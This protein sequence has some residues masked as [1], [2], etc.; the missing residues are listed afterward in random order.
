MGRVPGELVRF[1]RRGSSILL[2]KGGPGTGKTILSLELLRRFSK[3]STGIYLGTRVSA[4]RMLI[5]HP[6]LKGF[7][8]PQH[9]L[10]TEAPPA[11]RISISDTRFRESPMENLFEV[12]MEAENPFVVIDSWEVVAKRVGEREGN[13]A[14]EVLETLVA[15]K[16]T[17]LVFVSETTGETP[18]DFQADGMVALSLEEVEGRTLR[19]LDLRKLRGIRIGQRKQLFSLDRGRFH[20][21]P[22]FNSKGFG[23]E[24]G[25]K[26]IPDSKTHFSTGCV[27]LDR[28]LGGGYPRGGTVL[29]EVHPH[30]PRIVSGIFSVSVIANFFSQGRGFMGIPS[31][32]W[33]LGEITDLGRHLFGEQAFELPIRILTTA[34][35]SEQTPYIVQLTGEDMESDF[36]VW[37]KTQDALL[38]ETGQPVLSITH[39]RKQVDR[40]GEDAYVKALGLSVDSL[41]RSGGIEIRISTAGIENVTRKAAE[42][43]DTYLSIETRFGCVYLYGVKPFTS[44]HRIGVRFSTGV[45]KLDLMPVV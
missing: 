33:G 40:Y 42:L 37:R 26:T 16:K 1:L 3:R 30:V 17:N 36:E 6:W 24:V 29:L 38:E 8:D 35:P 32:S 25:W 11:G 44:I 20:Y 27:A 34:E 41:R 19:V 10:T 9:F 23:K 31:E 45:S 39:M 5:Q 15:S 12:A 28:L 7:V 4:E 13:K 2:I 22:P 14:L 18:L 21:L 43:A